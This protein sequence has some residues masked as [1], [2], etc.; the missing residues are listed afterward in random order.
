M[1]ARA[2]LLLTAFAVL[3]RRRVRAQATT[4]PSTFPPKSGMVK[5]RS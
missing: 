4:K 2:V 3:W 5:A 1:R